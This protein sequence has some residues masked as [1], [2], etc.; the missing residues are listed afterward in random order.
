MLI[1]QTFRAS[2]LQQ[3]SLRVTSPSRSRVRLFSPTAGQV[4]VT[5]GHDLAKGPWFSWG[6]HA[7]CPPTAWGWGTLPQFPPST[8]HA[9]PSGP[10]GLDPGQVSWWH[11]SL[12]TLWWSCYGKPLIR[13]PIRFGELSG[14]WGHTRDVWLSGI[15]SGVAASGQQV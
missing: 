13:A 12:A 11:N 3:V 6:S 15:S 8:P 10:C 7:Y 14:V 9:F 4:L 1:I 5:R 2:H